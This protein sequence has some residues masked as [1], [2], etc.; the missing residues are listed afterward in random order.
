KRKSSDIGWEWQSEEEEAPADD[1]D[2]EEAPTE[3]Q[4]GKTDQ[5]SFTKTPCGEQLRVVISHPNRS[6]FYLLLFL[7]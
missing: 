1:D 5:K 4:S 3:E 7:E 2:E 6:I